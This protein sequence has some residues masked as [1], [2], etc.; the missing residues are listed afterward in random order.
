MSRTLKRVWR[1]MNN[2][3]ERPEPVGYDRATQQAMLQPE[4][5][6]PKLS[7]EGKELFKAFEAELK[8]LRARMLQLEM[9]QSPW[10]GLLEDWLN[11]ELERRL[12]L[13][14]SPNKQA[15]LRDSGCEVSPMEVMRFKYNI[16]A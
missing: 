2:A 5:G 15:Y 14:L 7:D 10:T 9:A 6:P 12:G 11:R 8:A 3:K 16:G 13:Q 1:V 4:T